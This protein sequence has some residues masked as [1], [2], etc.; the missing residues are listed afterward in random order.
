MPVGV[1]KSP[2]DE[3]RWNDAKSAA[4]KTLSESDGDKYWALVMSIFK[5]MTKSDDLEKLESILL[6]VR[7]RLS[8]EPSEDDEEVA[9][10]EAG[11]RE[12]DPDEE[13]DDADKWLK[14]NEPNKETEDEPKEHDEYD[15]DEGEEPSQEDKTLGAKRGEIEGG[16]GDSEE[17]TRATISP[18]QAATPQ[19][20]TQEVKGRFPQPSKEEIAEMRGYTRPWEQN[21]REKARL[22][23]EAHKNPVLHHQG[24]MIEA[25]NAAHKTH[26][27]AYAEFQA[28]PEYQK[29]D[30]ITQMEMDSKF[31]S[32]F[33][34]QNPEYLA[35]A[36]KLHGQAHVAGLHG[37]GEGFGHKKENI[38]HIRSGGA[39]PETPMSVE[40][41]MQHVGGVKGEEGTVGS[42]V[43]DP[44]SSFAAHHKKFLDEMGA[45]HEEKAGGRQ[46]FYQK[47]AAGY[48]QKLGSDLDSIVGKHGADVAD[49]FK[50]I[51]SF[52]SI[53]G[54]KQ[55]KPEA[56]SK[57]DQ[58]FEKYHPLIGMH[59]HKVLNKLG[60]DKK[61]VDL[62]VL[63]EAGMH[64]LFQAINDYDHENP[65]KASFAT[66]A[67]NKIGGLMHTAMRNQMQTPQQLTSEAKKFQQ[68]EQAVSAPSA[69]KM[70][71]PEGGS[72]E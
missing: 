66:H 36:A 55:S 68:K 10:E 38:Q 59:A 25:R 64:G 20:E 13:G 49:R 45:K 16:T 65:S 60:L 39:M 69:A 47:R 15:A 67:G 9:P 24:R 63:H 4:N 58:F 61:N 43:Q 7:R 23:A 27:D 6:K 57:V 32:D 54:A 40:E 46:D 72:N 44:A 3:K 35:N 21:A 22:E 41:G 12:F 34:K 11:M 18:D 50:R 51:N 70:P 56:K 5:K 29:A 17:A 8:D 48:A 53:A 42:M 26:Q 14:E 52:K 30:P 19:E 31:E 37:M 62:G 33:H 71:K 2:R 1:V 28:S